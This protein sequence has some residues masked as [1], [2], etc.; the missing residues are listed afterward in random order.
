LRTHNKK[1]NSP[2]TAPCHDAIAS[3][4]GIYQAEMPILLSE[5]TSEQTCE[6]LAVS[7]F[8]A[9]HFVNG[10]VDSVKAEFLSL[11]SEF[12]LAFGSAVFSCYAHFEVGLGGVGNNFAEE[13]SKLCSV[14]C[15][16]VSCLFPVETD[17]RI[18]F[19]VCNA[20]HCK[21]HTYF[22]AFAF[23][24]SLKACDDV[25]VYALSYAYNVFSCP[26]QLGFVHFYELFSGNLA[27]RTFFRSAVAFVDVTA[28][29]ALKFL[30][31]QIL[32]ITDNFFIF[33]FYNLFDSVGELDGFELGCYIG[34]HSCKHPVK[35]AAVVLSVTFVILVETT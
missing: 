12:E 34:V 15:F 20:S 32:Q 16:F 14:F 13:F 10:V 5:V 31:F 11:L 30:H 25:S 22:G 2:K 8:V 9:C 18:A 7:C 4:I 6:C 28:Y 35:V 26:S 23:K 27:L 33:I 1:G 21:V 29:C 3:L 17:F 24:V 19:A